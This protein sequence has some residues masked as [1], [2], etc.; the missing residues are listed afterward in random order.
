MSSFVTHKYTYTARIQKFFI[1]SLLLSLLVSHGF[2]EDSAK[3]SFSGVAVKAAFL[4]N[5]LLFADW[6]ESVFSSPE[7]SIV[8]GILGED[9]FGDVFKPVEG[10][11]VNGKRLDIRRFKEEASLE[12]LK[13]CHLLF[14][15]PSLQTDMVKLIESLKDFPVLTVSE[16]KAFLESGGMIRLFVLNNQVKFEVNQWAAKHAG[17][18][19][20]SRLLR[21][22][23]RVVQEPDKADLN[24]RDY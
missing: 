24:K 3:S 7:E 23:S 17:I 8:I 21:L 19:L 13:Q 18:H 16:Q 2:A 4:Y 14:L 20:R 12:A 22:A 6:P 11:P 5:F 1:C 9:S 10:K 15:N